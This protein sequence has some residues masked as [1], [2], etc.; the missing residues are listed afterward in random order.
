MAEKSNPGSRGR[1]NLLSFLEA[2]VFVRNGVANGDTNDGRR[3]KGYCR[4]LPS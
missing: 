4:P 1:E 2:I 3:A